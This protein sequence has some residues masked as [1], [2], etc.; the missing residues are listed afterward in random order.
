[1]AVLTSIAAGAATGGGPVTCMGEP[2]TI[3]GTA[4]DNVILGTSARDVIHA[5]GGDDFVY[6]LAGD[7]VIC[8]GSGRDEIE[9]S[10]IDPVVIDLAAGVGISEDQGTD[11]FRSFE[12]AL[13]SR[14]DDHIL[15]TSGPN[16]VHAGDGGDIVS[17]RE[18][19]DVLDADGGINHVDGGPGRDKCRGAGVRV[20]CER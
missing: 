11:T 20:N 3:V 13:G 6:A 2:A 5:K 4:G 7:D 8:G 1:V 15:G 9:I 14:W 18:G 19:N 10:D 17:G 12:D 16:T